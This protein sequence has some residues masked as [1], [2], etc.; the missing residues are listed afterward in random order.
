M[1]AAPQ[2]TT[3]YDRASGQGTAA[4]ERGD[5]AAPVRCLLTAM[6]P[7]AL[8][9]L[10]TAGLMDLV[11]EAERVEC[12]IQA[13]SYRV[14]AALPQHPAFRR[15]PIDDAAIAVARA[16]GISEHIAAAQIAEARAIT[17]LFPETLDRLA[18]GDV[19]VAQVRALVEATRALDDQTARTVQAR[20]LHLMPDQNLAATRRALSRAVLKA[21]PDGVQRRHPTHP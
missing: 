12:A 11:A 7:D 18:S 10:D 17:R 8:A 13:A 16:L 4:H 6:Q 15:G 3:S 19:Q 20:V 1:K 14:L 9:R 5:P 21:D 2:N